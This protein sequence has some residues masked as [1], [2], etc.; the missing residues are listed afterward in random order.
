M[1]FFD[2]SVLYQ[3]IAV[4]ITEKSSFFSLNTVKLRDIN[5]SEVRH[6]IE[7]Y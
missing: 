5:L 4:S 6:V 7:G 1:K 2:L 3:N